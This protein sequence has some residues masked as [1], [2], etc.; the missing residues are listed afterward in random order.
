MSL[1]IMATVNNDVDF[2]T[3]FLVA[4]EFGVTANKKVENG[5]YQRKKA[6]FCLFFM[7]S[8]DN[9]LFHY[10]SATVILE[11]RL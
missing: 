9:L 4:S 3:A 5:S 8:V 2:D 6:F 10:T 7:N 11:M 1:G